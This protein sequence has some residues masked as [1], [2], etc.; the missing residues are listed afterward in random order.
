MFLAAPLTAAPRPVEPPTAASH[1]AIGI[2]PLI[3]GIAIVFLLIGA[4]VYGYRRR[5]RRQDR[6]PRA[7][8]RPRGRAARKA[9]SARATD[10]VSRESHEG[11]PPG[12][13]DMGEYG[14]RPGN[15]GEP[16]PWDEGK[17]GSFGNG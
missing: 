11:T 15:S 4:V 2:G 16:P 7:H 17:S 5:A 3:A 1:L 10:G 14:T 8:A 9:T 6:P 12:V 13:R